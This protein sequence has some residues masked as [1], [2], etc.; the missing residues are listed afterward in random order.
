MLPLI[1][2]ESKILVN[3]IGRQN[4]IMNSQD[5]K[6]E[7]VLETCFRTR[8]RESWSKCASDITYETSGDKILCCN[9]SA[10]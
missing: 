7:F 6:S 9:A 1:M 3:F 4:P 5:L 2:L 8:L 10:G